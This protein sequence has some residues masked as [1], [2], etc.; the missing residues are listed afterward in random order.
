MSQKPFRLPLV[1]GL[2]GMAL[3]VA[4]GA[5]GADEPTGKKVAAAQPAGVPQPAGMIAVKDPVTGKLRAATAEEAAELRKAAAAAKKQETPTA[6]GNTAVRRAPQTISGPE[7][8]VGIV[9]DDSSTIYA[10]AT[11][12]PDGKVSVKETATPKT[13]AAAAKQGGSNDK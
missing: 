9:L 8:A 13:G 7:G 2:L 12:K 5:A 1:A 3:A 11:K 6:Q 10:V 4:P